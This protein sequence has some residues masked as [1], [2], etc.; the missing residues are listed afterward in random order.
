MPEC[1]GWETP[2][3]SSQPPVEVE[4][5]EACNLLKPFSP[6][7]T[8][9]PYLAEDVVCGARL[10]ESVMLDTLPRVAPPRPGPVRVSPIK[11]VHRRI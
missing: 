9:L 1:W 10:A 5:E 6:A 4:V 7:R 11:L 8:T 3:R 2:K